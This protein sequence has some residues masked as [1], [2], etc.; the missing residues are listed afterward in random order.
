MHCIMHRSLEMKKNGREGR[1]FIDAQETWRLCSLLVNA[2]SCCTLCLPTFCKRMNSTYMPRKL[3]LLYERN[4]VRRIHKHL[5]TIYR[6]LETTDIRCRLLFLLCLVS[7][8]WFFSCH[9]LVVVFGHHSVN[10]FIN[11]DA[12]PPNN[13]YNLD[14]NMDVFCRGCL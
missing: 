12:P 8:Y 5:Q 3:R 9:E 10:K 13:S 14:Y 11:S 6:N 7:N 1:L 4:S 2:C